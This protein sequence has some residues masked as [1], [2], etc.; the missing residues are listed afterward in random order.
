M[1]YDQNNVFAR[2][3][4]G[5]LPSH[6]VYEDDLVL[7]MMDISPS[8]PGHLLVI[9]KAA[10]RNLF[11]A[12]DA[13]LAALLPVVQRLAKAALVGMGADGVEIRQFNEAPAGQTVFHLHVHIIPRWH[14]QPIRPHGAGAEKPEV[15]AANAER[16]RQAVV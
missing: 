6:K 1:S 5:E 9:P 2:I 11:D 3:L 10:S 14:D 13:T 8:S 16:I 12:S 7:A 15:L 4:R